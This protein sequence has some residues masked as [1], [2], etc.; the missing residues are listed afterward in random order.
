[1]PSIRDRVFRCGREADLA[2]LTRGRIMCDDPGRQT[3]VYFDHLGVDYLVI[4]DADRGCPFFTDAEGFLQ[5]VRS[6]GEGNERLTLWRFVN[7]AGR[8]AATGH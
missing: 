8:P 1:V 5:G 4:A 2:P 3:R 7:K 6:F